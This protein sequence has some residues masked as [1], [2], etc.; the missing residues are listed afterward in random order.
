MICRGKLETY[1]L[2]AAGWTRTTLPA[3]C[4]FRDQKWKSDSI[5]RNSSLNLRE[6]R[7]LGKE[8]DE[9]PRAGLIMRRF[10][11]QEV[12]V[13]AMQILN[14]SE[15]YLYVDMRSNFSCFPTA[16]NELHPFSGE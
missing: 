8:R 14:R 7:L 16:N 6:K 11:I 13:S 15:M 9:V 5:L 1:D 12:D 4:C 10:S 3:G 2:S